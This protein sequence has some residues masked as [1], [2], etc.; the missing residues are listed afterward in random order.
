M[1]TIT[2]IGTLIEDAKARMKDDKEFVTFTVA[3]DDKRDRALSRYYS[4]ILYGANKNRMKYLVKGTRVSVIG[5][6]Y[7]S[8]YHEEGRDPI[9]NLNVKVGMLELV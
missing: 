7:P 5:E 6:F 4:C 2:L 8:I 1:E 9:L 3:V